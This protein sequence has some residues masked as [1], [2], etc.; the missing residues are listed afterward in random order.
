MSTRMAWG[1]CSQGWGN[2]LDVPGGASRGGNIPLPFKIYRVRTLL[3][4]ST[5]PTLT[6]KNFTSS[7]PHL[8]TLHSIYEISDIVV[9]LWRSIFYYINGH[10]KSYIQ[11]DI[12]FNSSFYFDVQEHVFRKVRNIY[13]YGAGGE[14][15]V[16]VCVFW[17]RGFKSRH[18]P[19]SPKWKL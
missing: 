1:T 5:S 13:L 3:G 8:A 10:H 19:G 15:G 2:L 17:N 16:C 7:Y 4:L 9:F 14:K 11:V 12:M 6:T 18:V